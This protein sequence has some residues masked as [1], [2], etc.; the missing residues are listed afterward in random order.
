MGF[1]VFFGLVF[2]VMVNYKSLVKPG[3]ID[4]QWV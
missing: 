4:G 3:V 2:T 1:G